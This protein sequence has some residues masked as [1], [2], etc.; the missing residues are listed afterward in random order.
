MTPEKDTFRIELRN[1][2]LCMELD[3][4]TIFDAVMHRHCPS[5]TSAEF[6]PLESWIN[7]DRGQRREPA[8][9]E[10][11]TVRAAVSSLPRPAWLDRLYVPRGSE[12]ELAGASVRSRRASQHRRAG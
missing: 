4:N 6:Y 12:G 9:R 2:K 1:A 11:A 8:F 5:C 10:R 3:C 7:R